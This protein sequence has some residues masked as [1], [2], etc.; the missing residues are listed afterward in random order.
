MSIRRRK[1]FE[2][3]RYLG[4]ISTQ[5]IQKLEEIKQQLLELD[6][7]LKME[8]VGLRE[9]TGR[10]VDT[11]D[12]VTGFPNFLQSLSSRAKPDVTSEEGPT[13][14]HT[15]NAPDIHA[16]ALDIST[17]NRLTRSFLVAQYPD[18]ST[19]NPTNS[20][21]TSDMHQEPEIIDI[22]N[23][24]PQKPGLHGSLES[25]AFLKFASD[26]VGNAISSK[27]LKETVRVNKI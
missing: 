16:R 23:Q 17:E 14:S 20:Y 6:N 19:S 7:R 24:A 18:A 22:T 26:L 13:L 10:S 25:E 9:L 4:T 1:P 11:S 12:E 2:L 21:E 3:G 8:M 15:S 27:P 5:R